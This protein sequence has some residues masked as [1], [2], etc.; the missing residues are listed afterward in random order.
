MENQ[1]IYEVGSV[2]RKII[3]SFP[4]EDMDKIVFVIKE[5]YEALRKN[6]PNLRENVILAYLSLDLATDLFSTKEALRNLERRLDNAL[7]DKD[8]GTDS[9]L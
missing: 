7:K 1:Y 3:T 6:Y 9:S 5:K 8:E 2:K 4:P